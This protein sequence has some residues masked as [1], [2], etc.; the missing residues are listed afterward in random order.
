MKSFAYDDALAL[1]LNFIREIDRDDSFE[2]QSIYYLTALCYVQLNKMEDAVKF[3][4]KTE[5]INSNTETG[6]KAASLLKNL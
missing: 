3:L 1:F 4:K 2:Y 5:K 6:K